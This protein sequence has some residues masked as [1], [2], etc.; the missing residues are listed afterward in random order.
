MIGTEWAKLENLLRDYQITKI[1]GIF[2]PF[3]V[4]W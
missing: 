2:I 1:G 3:P 4:R